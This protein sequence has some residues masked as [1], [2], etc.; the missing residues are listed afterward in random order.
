MASSR[1]SHSSLR[2][3]G[4]ELSDGVYSSAATGTGG[5]VEAETLYPSR[6][7]TSS[8]PLIAG[9]GPAK[10]TVANPRKGRPQRL[11]RDQKLQLM[12]RSCQELSCSHISN[13]EPMHST[14]SWCYVK[15]KVHVK[16]IHSI[17]GVKSQSKQN[18][19][20]KGDERITTGSFCPLSTCW[21]HVPIK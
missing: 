2:S 9:R 15:V 7:P 16:Q 20:K 11:K 1:G 6:R 17:G 18:A 5:V 3:R 21:T 12:H 19:G 8:C 13:F 10:Q 4:S 14:T